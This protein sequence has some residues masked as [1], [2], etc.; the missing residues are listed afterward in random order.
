[1]IKRNDYIKNCVFLTR[2]RLPGKKLIDWEKRL[3]KVADALDVILEPPPVS[4][5][6]EHL[7]RKTFV[8][9]DT[10]MLTTFG[11]IQD[12]SITVCCGTRSKI[13][14]VRKTFCVAHNIDYPFVREQHEKVDST[15]KFSHKINKSLT[16]KMQEY[17]EGI[18]L[19]AW[20]STTWVL[21]KTRIAKKN[22]K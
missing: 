5:V 16:S 14:Y 1:M 17:T 4:D 11:F 8:S 3:A 18:C 7:F 15:I 19:T 2:K 21:G 22:Q 10:E 13:R 9:T 6:S 12:T 20:K